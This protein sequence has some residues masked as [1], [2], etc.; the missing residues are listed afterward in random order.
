MTSPY[1]QLKCNAMQQEREVHLVTQD[2]A[3]TLTTV[4]VEVDHTRTRVL[5]ILTVN[6]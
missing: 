4:F 2:K 6:P 1:R 3:F 5:R